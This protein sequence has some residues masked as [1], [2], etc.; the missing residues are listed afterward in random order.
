MAR[1]LAKSEPGTYEYSD[2]ERDGVADGNGGHPA[3]ALRH[4]PR[5]RP[6]DGPWFY[7]SGTERAAVG[8]ARITSE[9]RPDPTDDRGS[10][11]VEVRPV[12][13]LRGPVLLGALRSDPALNGLALFRGPRLGVLPLPPGQWS[14]IPRHEPGTVIRH[15][16]AQGRARGSRSSQRVAAARKR[17]AT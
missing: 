5:M 10:W 14:A 1:G 17:G 13:R 8:V 11:L 12:R 6:G 16:G 3:L 7:H 4:V 15:P 2:L 9:P